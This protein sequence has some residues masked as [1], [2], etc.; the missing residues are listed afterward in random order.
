MSESS[1]GDQ[2]PGIEHS[3]AG[4]APAFAPALI[5][6]GE[7]T[8]RHE[9]TIRAQWWLRVI[10]PFLLLGTWE[11]A[12]RVHM[13]MLA[14]GFAGEVHTRRQGRFGAAE[15]AFLLGW[16]SLFVALRLYN[17]PHLLGQLLTGN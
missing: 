3:S 17:F 6:R 5:R 15:G 9:W 14:R 13:A 11:R 10:S 7:N 2:S 12:E 4:N 8:G 16:G 1:R